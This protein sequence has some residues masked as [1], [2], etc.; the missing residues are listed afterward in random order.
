MK[1]FLMTLSLAIVTMAAM[2]VPVK[3]GWHTLKLVDGTEVRVQ[4]RG[5]E[6]FHWLEAADGTC[7]VEKNGVYEEVSFETLT[8][9]RESRMA[10]RSPHRAI[11]ASTTDGLGQFGKMS[12]GAVPSI[13]EYT[14]PVVMVQF[15]DLKFQKTTTVEKMTRYYNEEGYDDEGGTGSVRDYFIEQSG[16]QFVPTFDVVGLV[17]LNKSYSY[18]GGGDDDEH[19]Y[20]LPGDVIAAAVEQGVDF[21]KYVV[22]AGDSNHKT[23]VPLLAMFYAGRGAA[24]EYPNGVD[25]LWPCEWD[26]VEDPGGYGD[27]ND[28]HF[29][30]FFIGNELGSGGGSLMGCAVFCHEFGHAMGLPDFY[31]T[32][33]DGYSGDDPF[34]LWSIMDS[35]AYLDD[36]SRIPAAYNAYEK[37][38]MGWLDLKVLDTTADEVV[39]ANPENCGEGSAVIVRNSNTETFIIENHQPSKFFPEEFGEGVLVIR[40]AYNKTSW[41]NNNL[42]NI[43]S[44]KRACVLTANGA[45]MYYSAEKGNLYGYSKTAIGSLKTYSGGTKDIGIK[46]VTK[47]N[48]GTITLTLD[49]SS[50]GGGDDPV[51]TPT[52]KELFQE[53][54]DSFSDNKF[55]G[56]NDGQWNGGIAGVALKSSDLKGWT[57]NK[58]YKGYQCVRFGN[59]SST[60]TA[61][62]PA[63]SVESEAI[64]TFRAGA[65]DQE[66]DGTD[67]T[68]SVDNG[69]ISK[70]ATRAGSSS[71][72]TVTME[73]GAF[74]DYVLAINATGNVKVT[75]KSSKGRFFLDE[76]KVFD[77]NAT[78]GISN[79]KREATANNRYYTLDGRVLNGVPTQ[80]GIYIVNGKKVAIK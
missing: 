34:G 35:G 4:T 53:S 54:F 47:N 63:F 55:T 58:G 69:T 27:Y 6:N 30:S 43:Q 11:Y 29:N 44:K 48:D 18:Y 73:R 71:T 1:K 10:R 50:G 33:N 14:I 12:M 61:T 51:I 42:N 5:D 66:D 13:G 36:D 16:G 37:S 40:I 28:V 15:K 9:H 49:G 65:W 72:T 67:L 79:V 77:P 21:S 23:G 41:N 17:T 74:T 19:L 25:Y 7:Y 64:L 45:K 80:K 8:A 39:L 78:T 52:G 38:Y 70:T 56:G 2:A 76:V 68:V 20:E 22:P 3:P 46:K 32:S 31:V 62:T 57:W 75:F 59:S 26:D 24:T 60:G